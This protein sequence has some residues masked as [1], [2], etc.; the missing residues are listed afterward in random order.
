MNYI[1]LMLYI[2]TCYL[3]GSIPPAYILGRILKKTDIREHGSGNV[4]FT[5]ALRVLGVVPGIITLVIDIAKGFLPIWCIRQYGWFVA[6]RFGVPIDVSMALCGIAVIAGHNWPIYI[7]FRGGKG[8]ATGCGIFLGMAPLSTLLVVLLW[9]I[10]LALTNIVSISSIIAVLALPGV[11][12]LL[13]ESPVIITIGAVLAIVTVARHHE[14]IKRLIKG[15][16]R[17]F[18]KKK[19]TGVNSEKKAS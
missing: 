7:G 8:V 14:N 9:I 11:M 10:V 19:T 17:S 5:N 12:F 16:E 2:L 3:I 1:Y 15:E 18:R 4:G 13:H 6:E